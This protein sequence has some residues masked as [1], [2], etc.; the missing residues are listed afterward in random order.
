MCSKAE[1]GFE[2]KGGFVLNYMIRKLNTK[3]YEQTQKVADRNR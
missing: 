3:H 2:E 1:W